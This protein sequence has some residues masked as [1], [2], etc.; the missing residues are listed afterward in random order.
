MDACSCPVNPDVIPPGM[1]TKQMFNKE[2]F[3]A[4]GAYGAVAILLLALAM[5][6]STDG[7]Q[8]GAIP[9]GLLL[10]NGLGFNGFDKQK[11]AKSLSNGLILKFVVSLSTIPAYWWFPNRVNW[12]DGP[13]GFGMGAVLMIPAY[14]LICYALSSQSPEAEK[15]S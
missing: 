1:E 13:M 3:Y 10:F 15:K 14:Y 12:Y 4:A 8:S 6:L 2:A 9:F 5:T 7:P 11:F